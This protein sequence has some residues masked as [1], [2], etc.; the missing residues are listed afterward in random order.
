MIT[1]FILQASGGGIIN[2]VFF[3]GIIAVMYF[4]FMRPQMK[5]QKEQAAFINEIKKGDQVA[6]SS[7][8]I[9]KVNKIEANEISLQ[10]DSKTYL[11]VTKS[12][13]SK[14][15]TDAINAAPT[16]STEK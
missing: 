8:I 13:I 4:F 2:L 15:I 12:A 7:G 10:V 3:A 5:K 6:L 1:N 11:R 16:E 14:E 9:G